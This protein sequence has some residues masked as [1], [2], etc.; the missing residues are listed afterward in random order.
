MKRPLRISPLL[1]IA[2]SLLAV[3]LVAYPVRNGITR[4]AI[5]L[6]FPTI[7]VLLLFIIWR[8]RIARYSLIAT[9]VIVMVVLVSPGREHDS[10]DLQKA[11]LSS[12]RAYIGTRYVW[13]GENRLGV[14]CSGLIRAAMVDALFKQ[15]IETAN[16]ALLREGLW[17][18][19]HDIAARDMPNGYDGRMQT[20]IASNSLRT[21]A[22]QLLNPGDA[23]VTGDGSHVIAY[24]G[25]DRWIEADPVGL[26]VVE[27][28]AN[29]RRE[30]LDRPMTAVRWGYLK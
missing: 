19:W 30:S 29:D 13:G 15:G 2:L 4:P 10:Q 22:S 17:L 5:V 23:A 28:S 27:W 26:Q 12:L 25:E 8:Q 21:E 9:L 3:L 11:Y 6:I 1:F 24:L 7:Y 16:P 20:I 14:D 18:W